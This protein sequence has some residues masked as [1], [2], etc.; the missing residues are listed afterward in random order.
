MLGLAA[1]GRP[2]RPRCLVGDSGSELGIQPRLRQGCGFVP[3]FQLS[4]NPEVCACAASSRHKYPTHSASKGKVNLSPL[5]ILF[6][7]CIIDP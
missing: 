5:V 4:Y 6:L 3:A 1:I 2:R 7:M